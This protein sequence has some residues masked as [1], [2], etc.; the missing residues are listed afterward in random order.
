MKGGRRFAFRAVVVVGDKQGRVGIGIGKA[1]E[2][3]DAI[4]KA[5]ERAKKTLIRVP[6]LNGT[7]PH[8]VQAKFGAGQVLLKPASPGTGVIAGGGVR[9]VVE[10]AGISDILSKS[11]GSS[12]ILNVVQATFAALQ[13]TAGFPAG[14][15]A[16][17]RRSEA[18]GALL[19]QGG[20]AM[21]ETNAGQG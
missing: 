20:D 13:G 12:N 6:R 7:I 4:R 11:L 18:S 10:A 14:G 8:E 19:V 16:P 15:C 3:P 21:A 1:R 9:A 2:V 5:S 17:W